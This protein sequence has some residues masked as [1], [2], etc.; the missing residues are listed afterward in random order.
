VLLRQT[1]DQFTFLL[2]QVLAPDH[3][4]DLSLADMLPEGDRLRPIG[5]ASQFDDLAGKPGVNVRQAIG[6]QNQRA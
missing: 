2:A 3:R 4:Q 5:C 6:I 1:V